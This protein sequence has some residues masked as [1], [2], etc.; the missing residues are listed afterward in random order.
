MS[1]TTVDEPKNSPVDVSKERLEGLMFIRVVL[2]TVFLGS[3]LA[4]EAEALSNLTNF[5]N[6]TLV[7]L[8]VSTYVLTII[9]AVLHRRLRSRRGLAIAQITLDVIIVGA[10]VTATGGLSSVFTFL[11]FLN[12][13]T[14]AAVL[15]SRA[16][17]IVAIATSLILTWLALLDLGFIRV[18]FFY[19]VFRPFR[20]TVFMVALNIAAGFLIAALSGF[21]AARLGQATEAIERQR[22]DIEELR[23]LNRNI[24]ESLSS[25]LVTVDDEYQIIFFNRAAEEITGWDGA[26]ALGRDLSAVFPH[27]LSNLEADFR[28]AERQESHYR[29]PDG[30]LLYLGF[31]LSSLQDRNGET[32]GK[33]LIFQD[34]SQIRQM[35][36]EMRRSERL[37]AI[38]QLSASIA[39]E[40]R[41]PLAA[42]SGAV[43]LIQL[44][45]GNDSQKRLRG[46]VL[47]EVDRL[48]ALISD[49]LEYCRPYHPT[50]E[51][52]SLTEL[53]EEILEL[54]ERDHRSQD[55]DLALQGLDQVTVHSDA[56]A[57]RQVVVNLL[58]N[59][60]ETTPA[61]TRVRVDVELEDDSTYLISV[62]D[63]GPGINESQ[64]E[65]L[66]E[67]FFT[68][69]SGG[70]GLGLATAFRLMQE[71]NGSIRIAPPREFSGARFELRLPAG[72]EEVADL[73]EDYER[74]AE[75]T[76]DSVDVTNP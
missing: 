38:G 10:L 32:R 53:L 37:A 1:A 46:V 66:F 47:R 28:T 31:S 76:P 12:I 18:P 24:L 62:E 57:I 58:V 11:F 45:E 25:G 13:I 51:Q 34:L 5:R 36:I 33:I 16:S 30:K 14:A 50:L 26:D 68:T 72:L 56:H 17:F 71:I 59:S 41:N 70:S 43:E 75:S 39:H 23:N 42:I 4:I 19:P 73:N 9:Y 55:V 3:A 6:A 29:R 22:V 52:F 40:I 61:P 8:I 60:F 48:N 65:R 69:K 54:L 21:L 44:P 67:P 64:R 74:M 20:N 7:T 49:F 15:G 35:E 27:L 63:D 2:V